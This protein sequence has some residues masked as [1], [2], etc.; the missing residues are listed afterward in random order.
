[1]RIAV[2]GLPSSGKTSLI[3]KI[4][5]AFVVS[6]RQ[7]LERLTDGKFSSMDE[8]GKRAARI[9]YTEFLSEIQDE[10]VVSDGHYSFLENVVFTPNDGDV[11]DVIFYLYCKPGE[12][13]RRCALSEKNQKYSTLSEE[14]IRQWQDF[15]IESLREE[16]HK[17]N[18]DF[19][20]I[21]DNEDSTSFYDF[22]NEVVNG[23]SAV[24]G[25]RKIASKISALYP[26]ETYGELFI[27]DGDKTV[28]EQD[29]FRFCYDGKTNVFDG[30]FYSGYQSYLYDQELKAIG[31]VPN[32]I[33]EIKL[34]DDVWNMIKDN[35]YVVL[36][37]GITA[38]WNSLKDIFGFKEV[39]ADPMISADSKYYTVKFLKELGYR[40]SAFGDSRNDY[41]MLQEADSGY[42]KIGKRISRS[43]ANTDLTGIRLLYDKHPYILVEEATEE[44]LYDMA[45][46]KSNSGINGNRLASAHLR[47]GQRMGS[48]MASKYPAKNTA[49]LVLERGGRFFGD[50]LYSAFGGVF[51]PYNPSTGVMP[52]IT[53]KRVVIV[54]SVINTGKSIKEIV[55]NLKESDPNREIVIAT[56]VIQQAAI[57]LLAD[58][59]VFAVRSSI[60]SFVGKRQA[61]QTGKSGPDTADRLFNIIDRSF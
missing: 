57:D 50:G 28:I 40:I 58:Y 47:L 56:N 21:S 60:N 41:Y 44:D 19:Y 38:V 5:N 35:P 15:E 1:M 36:S 8:D 30:D 55:L 6:G 54:D 45:V 53:Q 33:N 32:S 22:F 39:V 43:L 59:K 23:L 27:A 17:R 48:K 2:Y 26:I 16:C 3:E 49:V 4:P 13:L 37:S 14:T 11:Y 51:Y 7:E 31:P 29:S 20:V 61:K 9:Q 25:A 52:E 10:V 42:L 24:T 18:K 12:V 34:N 46:C